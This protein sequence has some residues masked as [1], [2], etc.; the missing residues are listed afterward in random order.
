MSLVAIVAAA[1]AIL[2][3]V[4]SASSKSGRL[5]MPFKVSVGDRVLDPPAL[6]VALWAETAL[7]HGQR[8][9]AEEAD[10][11]LLLTYAGEHVF[12]GTNPPIKSVLQTP[13]LYRWQLDVLRKNRIRY[14]VVDA[15]TAS[16]DVTSGYFF[17][18][19]APA[20]ESRFSRS[21]VT[22]FERAGA[23]RLYDNGD[24]VVDDLSE[25][26]YADAHP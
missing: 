9:A 12:A 4:V 17:S 11:R 2:G 13:T 5:G 15:R 20:E 21:V 14:V 22:K 26:R 7:G 3:G 8:V 18:Q 6:A 16:A 25:I 23:R 24:I 10:A 19:V 1:V